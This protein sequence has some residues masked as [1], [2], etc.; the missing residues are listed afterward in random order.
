MTIQAIRDNVLFQFVDAINTNNQFVKETTASG[1]VL[2]GDTFDSSAKQSRWIKIIAVGPDVKSVKVGDEALLPA[3]RW[4]EGMKYDGMKFW[5]TDEREIVCTR[6]GPESEL[7][8]L[9]NWV[10]FQ[11][12][13]TQNVRQVGLIAVFG[14][15]D[16]TPRGRAFA[17]G[18]KAEP[19]LNGAVFYYSDTNFTETAEHAGMQ[20]AFVRDENILVYRTGE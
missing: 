5:K 2:A 17:I 9:T 7:T 13:K 3:L 1:I 8:P 16:E 6:T 10:L 15:V 19:E 12:L 11:Q 14:G 4:T 18:P 20:I